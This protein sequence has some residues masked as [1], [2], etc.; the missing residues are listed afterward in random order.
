MSSQRPYLDV[1]APILHR[2][3]FSFHTWGPG[4]RSIAATSEA[5][6][7]LRQQAALGSQ[8]S[9]L[10]QEGQSQVGLVEPGGYSMEPYPTGG[11]RAEARRRRDI[12]TTARTTCTHIDEKC[13]CQDIMSPLQSSVD[14]CNHDKRPACQCGDAK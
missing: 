12:R 10:D 4:L 2:L 13:P 1:F 6:E 3:R 14:L 8:A 5:V 9:G 7:T 11:Q